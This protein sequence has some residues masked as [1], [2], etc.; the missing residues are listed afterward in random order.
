MCFLYPMDILNFSMNTRASFLTY[1][2]EEL[3]ALQT[4]GTSGDTTPHPGGAEEYDYNL[5]HLQ[6][7]YAPLVQKQPVTTRSIKTWCP[8]KESA[9]RDYFNTTVWDELMNPHG[10]D[11]EEMTHYQTWSPL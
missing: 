7:L 8:E 10:E 2:R 9:L 1:S 6:P 3:L 4:K 5:V 11:I